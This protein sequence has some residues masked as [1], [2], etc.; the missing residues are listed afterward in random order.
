MFLAY[1]TA[2]S[3]IFV[4]DMEKIFLMAEQKTIDRNEFLLEQGQISQHKIFVVKGLLR[5]FSLSDEGNEHILQFNP[6]NTWTLDVES[7]D[8]GT[9]ARF[10]ISAVEKSEVLIWEKS[11]FNSLLEEIPAF[12][13]LSQSIISRNI[14]SSR[15]RIL[16]AISATPEEKYT[17]FVS[18]NFELLSRLPLFMIASYLGISLKTLT[19]VRRAQF[20]K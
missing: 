14:Y 10:N 20:Q 12:R 2:S 19:R 7:Y 11:D 9:P 8:N 3:D 6:E 17:E 16:T 4:P 18:Q 13:S 1:L 5:N 15:Q